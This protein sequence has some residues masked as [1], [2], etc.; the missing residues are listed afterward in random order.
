MK[1]QFRKQ[2]KTQIYQQKIMYGFTIDEV[3]RYCN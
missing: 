1:Q 2:Y 3:Y